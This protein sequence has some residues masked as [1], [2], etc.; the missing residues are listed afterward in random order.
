MQIWY[1]V[2]NDGCGGAI[3]TLVE[4]EVLAKWLQEYDLEGWG[5]PCYGSIE[6]TGQCVSEVE[7]AESCL[8]ELQEY[9]CG[10]NQDKYLALLLIIERKKAFAKEFV[11]TAIEL[12]RAGM[13][14]YFR[15]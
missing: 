8:A 10:V 13:P 9:G 12:Q 4:S 14:E 2:S 5:E 3:M 6:I 1:S 11:E 15:R 7:T